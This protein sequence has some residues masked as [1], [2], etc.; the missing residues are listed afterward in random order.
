[1][2]T[3]LELT[4]NF[5]YQHEHMTPGPVSMP[6]HELEYNWIMYQSKL[7]WLEI[8]NLDLPYEEMLA[9]AK[10]LRHRFVAHRQNNSQGWLS[11]CVHGISAEQTD[12]ASAYGLADDQVVYGYT[13]IQDLCPVTV[14]AFR[15]NF[16]YTSYMRIRYMLV[17]P[18][19]YI[20]PHTDGANHI[21]GAVN[22]SL[23]NPTGCRLVT[24]CGTVPFKHSGS[25]MLFNTS[26]RHAVWNNSDQDRIHMIVHG[27]PD[28]VFWQRKVIDSFMQ[29][30]YIL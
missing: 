20:S 18:G 23:N 4:K 14:N 22:I 30:S 16:H 25:A 28:P 11:L 26:Y 12:A 13:E 8:Q 2:L 19:G 21:L 6:N 24:E 27:L 17:E 29:S 5:V 15:H 9:E 7:P 3:D 1:M 10:S